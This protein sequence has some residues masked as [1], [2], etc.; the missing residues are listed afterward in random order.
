MKLET[1][2][3]FPT[4]AQQAYLQRSFTVADTDADNR[5]SKGEVHALLRAQVLPHSP[6]PPPLSLSLARSRYIRR[7]SE[8]WSRLEVGGIS[9]QGVGR[10]HLPPISD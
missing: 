9:E 6:P 3:A 4:R 1:G 8:W 7:C 10:R 2:E 5:L